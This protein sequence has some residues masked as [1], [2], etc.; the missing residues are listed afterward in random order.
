MADEAVGALFFKKL[1]F[2]IPARPFLPE[3]PDSL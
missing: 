3:M 1:R 2:K